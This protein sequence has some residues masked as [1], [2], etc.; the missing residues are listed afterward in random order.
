MTDSDFLREPHSGRSSSNARPSS[1]AKAGKRE[2]LVASA[3][4][5]FHHKGFGA[6]AL[7]DIAEHSKVPLGNI[8]YYYRTKDDLVRAVIDAQAGQVAVMLAGLDEMSGPAERLAALAARWDLMRDVVA[9][10]GC[11]F[12]SLASELDR[13]ADGLDREAAVPLTLILRWATGQFRELG[14]ADPEQAATT[15]L[16]GIQ[17]SSLL[18]SALR[19]PDLLTAQIRHLQAWIGSMA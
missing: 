4:E 18:A 15:L 2:R 8:Y 7:A 3:A 16:A 10:H 6:T 9:R 19:D 13:R 11:P 5:L 17:G 12:G 14:H 1:G